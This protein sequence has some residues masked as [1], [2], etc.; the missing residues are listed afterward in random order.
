[1]YA[2]AEASFKRGLDRFP[3]ENP[4][5]HVGL[6]RIA[7]REGRVGEASRL[8]ATAS[9]LDAGEAQAGFLNT[10]AWILTA[11]GDYEQSLKVSA[12]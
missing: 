10:Y 3:T 6:A 2:N 5:F 9:A 1:D 4:T 11:L 7:L 8:M 12:D